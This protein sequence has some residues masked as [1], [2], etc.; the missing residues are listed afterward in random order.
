MFDGRFFLGDG[1][2]FGWVVIV[3]GGLDVVDW[4]EL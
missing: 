2:W 1:G 4:I 3:V